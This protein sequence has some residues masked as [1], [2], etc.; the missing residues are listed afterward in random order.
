MQ[1]WWRLLFSFLAAWMQGAMAEGMTGTVYNKV[2]GLR[3]DVPEGWQ[4]QL[5]ETGY[6]LG[7][8][9]EPGVVLILPHPYTNMSQLQQESAVPLDDGAG[10]RLSFSAVRQTLDGR[11]LVGTVSGELQGQAVKGELAALVNSQGPGMM[12]VALVA[13]DQYSEHY[14]QLAMEIARSVRFTAPQLGELVAT[15]RTSLRDARLAYLS[16]YHRAG[17]TYDGYSTGGSYSSREEIHLC[18][19]GQFRYASDSSLSVDTG[20]AFG[21]DSDSDRGHGRWEVKA[22]MTGRPLLH[23]AFNDGSATDYTLTLENGKTY[24]NGARY[25]RTYASDGADMGPACP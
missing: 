4:A 12:V 16:S 3:F 10:T 24:L 5:G 11:A 19:D 18:R 23:L 14:Q 22:D 9:K 21:H 8:L 7:S 15:W 6:V 25:Y 17:S 20:G 1:F 2:A 13:Q